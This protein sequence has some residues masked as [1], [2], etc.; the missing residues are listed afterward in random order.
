M[1]RPHLSSRPGSNQA[2][3]LVEIAIAIG[4]LAVALVALLGML[5]AGMGNFRKA[6]DTSI[7]AQIAQKIL[8]D[9]E[10]AEFDEVIDVTHLPKDPKDPTNYAAPHF[11]FRAPSVGEPDQSLKPVQ[12]KV[13]FFTD[14]GAEVFPPSPTPTSYPDLSNA[15]NKDVAALV[16]YHVNVRIIPRAELPTV[17]EDGS[18]VAQI[19]IQVARNPGP[20]KILIV[21]GNADD[22]NIPDRNLFQKTSGVAIFTYHALIGKNQGK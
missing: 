19:T 12:T 6:M 13:R 2:F 3:T 16:V 7:T 21:S 17:N 10:E 9:L 8:H 4:I 18:Q 20:R 5:P 15:A 11:S 1:I 14:Q 22:A